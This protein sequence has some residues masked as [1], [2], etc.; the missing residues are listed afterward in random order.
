MVWK[1][2]HDIYKSRGGLQPVQPRAVKKQDVSLCCGSVEMFGRWRG[3][4]EGVLNIESSFNVA[5]IDGI[6]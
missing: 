3:H 1:D 6:K 2:I 4:F 5:T